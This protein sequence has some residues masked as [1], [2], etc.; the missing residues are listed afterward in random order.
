MSKKN[1]TN[2][3]V[4][5]ADYAINAMRTA[6]INQSVNG[7]NHAITKAEAVASGTT[8]ERWSQWDI[9]VGD[10]RDACQHYAELQAD[11]T[12]SDN[13]KTLKAAEGKVWAHWRSILKVG[14]EDLFHK[15]MFI[16]RSDVE[17]LTTFAGNI[18]YVFVPGIGKVPAV[19]GKN[20]F[21]KM[22]ECF[23]AARIAGNA[24]LS[25][26]QRDIVKNYNNAVNNEKKQKELLNGSGEE[27]GLLK[28][29]ARKKEAYESVVA[30]LKAAN[31][32]EEQI[33]SISM[34]S[35][36]AYEATKEA[37]LDAEKALAN[38]EKTQKDLKEQYDEIVALLDK[39]EAPQEAPTAA[40]EKTMSPD[41]MKNLAK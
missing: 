31:L 8:E 16:R 4:N 30:A 24:M 34:A 18:T 21:R 33:N 27:E 10:L 7:V 36:N 2:A 15:N 5:T 9:W 1:E 13:S 25:D 39:L 6:I 20:N 40:P 26:A 19:T 38:A 28:A 12:I 32:P 23:L 3:T 37:R 29:E 14:E 17:K 22:V 35:K 41:E 11:R